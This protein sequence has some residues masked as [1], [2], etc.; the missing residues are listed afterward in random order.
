M[1]GNRSRG[2]GERGIGCRRPFLGNRDRFDGRAGDNQAECRA[3]LEEDYWE[4]I[5]PGGQRLGLH[6]PASGLHVD[7][8][9][10]RKRIGLF[11]AAAGDGLFAWAGNDA[12]EFGPS[13]GSPQLGQELGV[14]GAGTAAASEVLNLVAGDLRRRDDR[15]ELSDR[16]GGLQERQRSLGPGEPRIAPAPLLPRRR[17]VLGKA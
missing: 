8:D 11:D 9:R 1:R 17:M 12:F 14:L 10:T 7:G 3:E 6:R 16:P 5:H 2:G 4:P 15:L 13:L